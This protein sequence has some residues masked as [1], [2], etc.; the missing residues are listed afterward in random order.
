MQRAGGIAQRGGLAAADLAGQQPDGADAKDIL[1]ALVDVVEL[2]G[3]QDLIQGQIGAKGFFLQA[4]EAAVSRFH[5]S[6]SFL[7]S[8]P[9]R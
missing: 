9:P 2:G 1:E 4:E 7:Q 6:F 5:G 8:A 3:E